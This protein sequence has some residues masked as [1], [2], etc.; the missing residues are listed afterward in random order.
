MKFRAGKEKQTIKSK[1]LLMSSERG[2]GLSQ[3]RNKNR[4][5]FKNNNNKEN[6][7]PKKGSWQLKT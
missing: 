3:P 2:G 4:M 1:L 6:Q 5:P 7:G